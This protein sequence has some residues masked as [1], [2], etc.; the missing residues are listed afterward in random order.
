LKAREKQ[1]ESCKHSLKRGHK[2]YCWGCLAVLAKRTA[3]AIAVKLMK[4]RRTSRA[5]R[6]QVK[7]LTAALTRVKHGIEDSGWDGPSWAADW[8]DEQLAPPLPKKRKGRR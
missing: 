5:L 8:L 6:A 4:E 7:R 1:P 2:G 3:E